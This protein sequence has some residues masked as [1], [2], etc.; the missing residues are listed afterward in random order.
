MM[1]RDAATPLMFALW[2]WCVDLDQIVMRISSFGGIG[3]KFAGC[4]LRRG[5]CFHSCRAGFDRDQERDMCRLH[6]HLFIHPYRTAPPDS[7]RE[8]IFFL[9]AKPHV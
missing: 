8:I 6:A 2:T 9:L 7:C 1:R 3:A 4:H 5:G